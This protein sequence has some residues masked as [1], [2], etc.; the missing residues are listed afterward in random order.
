VPAVEAHVSALNTHLIA[1]L[2]EL[3]AV[4]VTPADPVRRGPLVCVR[5]TDAP[6]LVASVAEENIVCSLRDENLRVAAHFYNTADDIDTL[7]E[8][9]G[10]RRHLL[11]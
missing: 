2:E 10:R 4:V 7:L 1:G 3:G 9:L 5:S 6:A 8:A 11:A